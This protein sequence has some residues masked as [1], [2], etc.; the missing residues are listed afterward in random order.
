MVLRVVWLCIGSI[1]LFSCG[2]DGSQA[3]TSA[4]PAALIDGKKLFNIH[5]AACHKYNGTGGISGAKDLT[6]SL[7]SDEEM[8]KIIHN[9][10]GDMMPFK[11]VISQAEIDAVVTHIH[12]LKP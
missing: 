10:A 3:H 9:G 6:S 8:R 7:L 4:E 5:C 11:D 2:G 1:A 12:T